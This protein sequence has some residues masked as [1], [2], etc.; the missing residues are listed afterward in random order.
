MSNSGISKTEPT[1]TLRWLITGG[2]GFIGTALISRLMSEGGAL[3]SRIGQPLRRR[4]GRPFSG[5][6]IPRS[7]PESIPFGII[8]ARSHPQA[9]IYVTTLLH[10]RTLL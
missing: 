1:K 9:N 6:Y 2:C 3:R 8:I 7:A 10:R 5:M 4:Q